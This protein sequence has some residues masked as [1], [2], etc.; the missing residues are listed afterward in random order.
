[1]VIHVST[2][3]LIYSVTI[4]LPDIFQTSKYILINSFSNVYFFLLSARCTGLSLLAR[5]SHTSSLSS[6]LSSS[7]FPTHLSRVITTR[8]PD[9]L[10]RLVPLIELIYYCLSE[11]SECGKVEEHELPSESGQLAKLKV[12]KNAAIHRYM[13]LYE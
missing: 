7:V 8:S 9:C 6:C 4:K 5:Q 1:M 13:S 11:Q 3:T 10:E 12:S 2:R